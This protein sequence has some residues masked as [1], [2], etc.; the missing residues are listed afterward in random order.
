MDLV[1]DLTKQLSRQIKQDETYLAYLKCYH[2]VKED[3]ELFEKMNEMRRRNI[4]LQNDIDGDHL[5]EALN[6]LQ[7]EYREVINNKTVSDFMKA[8][9]RF[10]RK[11]QKIYTIL[12]QDLD[13]DLDFLN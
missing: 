12:N 2:A 8:E 13:I 7:E 6:H 9:M 4:E 11:M 1:L 5:F 10:C 3:R